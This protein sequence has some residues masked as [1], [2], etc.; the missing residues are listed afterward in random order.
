MNDISCPHCK[1]AFKVDEAGYAS[2]LQQVRNSEFDQEI[3]KRLELA[4][5]EKANAVALANS[6]ADKN[7]QQTAAAK[8]IE[9]QELKTK[10]DSIE[11]EKKLAVKEAL[12]GA[13]KAK[14]SICFKNC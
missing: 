13:I 12:E 9:I 14:Q 10:L 6:E 2:L 5:K 3:R 7:V 1:K 8:D 11:V 4:E